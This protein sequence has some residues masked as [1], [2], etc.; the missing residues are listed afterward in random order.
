MGNIKEI[1]SLDKLTVTQVEIKIVDIKTGMEI[2]K[3]INRN[4]T[5]ADKVAMPIVRNLSVLIKKAKS[6]KVV[7]PE[8]D[9]VK[10]SIQS[11]LPTP[12]PVKEE[13]HASRS[14]PVPKAQADK[15]KPP[16]AVKKKKVRSTE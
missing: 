8:K 4:S 15:D 12:K 14:I 11:V 9:G 6:A 13:D 5:D 1:S 2:L 7:E 10:S 16:K 3:A